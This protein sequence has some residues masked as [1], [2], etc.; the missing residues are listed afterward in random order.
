MEKYEFI[1][2]LNTFHSLGA[3]N[4]NAF[5]ETNV[6]NPLFNKIMV[7]REV[8]KHIIS[9]ITKR[10]PHIFILTGHAG[11]GKTALLIQAL[12]QWNVFKSNSK[13]LPE[14][15]FLLPNGKKCTYVKDFSEDV[16]SNQVSKL[17]KYKNKIATGEYV[18]LVA[19]TGPLLAAFEKSFS[20]E[21]QIKLIN[22]IDEND[23][24]IKIY[25]NVPVAV[26]NVATI[27]NST[28]VKPFL[29]NVL[30]EDNWKECE[31]CSKKTSC[32]ILNN[33]KIMH[34]YISPISDFIVKHYIYQQE[35]DKKLTIRQI[36]A[37][38]TYSITGG[39]ECEK[40]L[41]LTNN[42]LKSLYVFNYLFTNLF[43]GYVG[44][45]ISD[46][47]RTLKAVSDIIKQGYDEKRLQLDEKLF[48]KNDLTDIPEE[49]RCLLKE[50][51][52]WKFKT[53]D[54]SLSVDP[55]SVIQKASAARK[56]ELM[57]EL[58]QYAIR[59]AYLLTNVNTNEKE[60]RQL[61]E[62]AFSSNYSRFLDL[63]K[64]MHIGP[65]EK[66]LVMDALQMLFMGNIQ[67]NEDIQITLKRSED[68]Q[69]SVQLGLYSFNSREIELRQEEVNDFNPKKRYKQYIFVNKIKIT[70]NLSLPLINYFNEI[71][72]GVISTNIDPML[73]Q[74][75]DSLKAQ[76]MSLCE[77]G[78]KLELLNLSDK[79]WLPTKAVYDETRNIWT[80][81]ER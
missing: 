56:A 67:K 32:P 36:V 70:P 13:L 38:L 55:E 59:R 66:A 28:F 22:A 48:I 64:G 80:I 4:E 12:L 47:A 75:I 43:F 46:E 45:S 20:P 77:K 29:E 81:Y 11:D 1:R 69:Q 9:I 41:N 73:S 26:I 18:F 65:F 31:F 24:V 72:R 54:S 16:L 40:V 21:E 33:Q 78:D 71:S 15:E 25:E 51:E 49:V 42:S 76:I 3:K 23:G 35:Y 58:R 2:F 39:L 53:D 34:K 79:G 8:G 7:D 17:E 37:H 14:D 10:E 74:G 68:V 5:A 6:T 27:D 19:N 62:D 52:K 30:N 63:R 44:F 50:S 61:L 60:K 57:S